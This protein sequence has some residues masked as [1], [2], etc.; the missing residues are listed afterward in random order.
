MDVKCN[1]TGWREAYNGEALILLV[2][3]R[4]QSCGH[5]VTVS[6]FL[7]PRMPGRYTK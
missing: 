7:A 3:F 1:L 4:G 2:N 6:G 5:S